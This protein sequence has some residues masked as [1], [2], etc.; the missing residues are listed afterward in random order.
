MKSFSLKTP[1][2]TIKLG[3]ALG[4]VLKAGDVICLNGDLGAGKTLLSKSIAEGMEIAPEEV[5]SPT[6]AIMNIY[7]SGSIPIYHFDWYRLN[8]VD[9]LYDIGYEEYL[10]SD[11][12]CLIEWAELFK[13]ELPKEYLDINIAIASEG[14]RTLIITTYGERYEAIS[15]KVDAIVN[16]RD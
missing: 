7:D 8:D 6:F 10:D 16:F 3:N 11:G 1:K 2:D 4:S 9:E 15:E 13:E 14:G 5:T 12:V